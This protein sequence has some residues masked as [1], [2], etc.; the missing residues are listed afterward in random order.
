MLR[1]YPA[2]LRVV[3][4]G[5]RQYEVI[6]LIRSLSTSSPSIPSRDE[7]EEME[8]CRTWLDHF[9]PFAL[10]NQRSKYEFTTSRS[11]GPGGQNVNKIESKTTLHISLESLVSIGLPKLLIP[12]VESRCTQKNGQKK[13]SFTSDVYRR[14][15]DNK[16][17][18]F[19][20]LKTMIEESARDVIRGP[21][22]PD[23]VKRIQTR[24]KNAKIRKQISKEHLKAKKAGRRGSSGGDY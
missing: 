18:C 7:E 6:P 2:I 12:I 14:Q 22:D 1:S 16:R 17:E 19:A 13:L 3:Q 5:I 23:R 15:D 9:D 20:R 10:Q 11:S 4:G 21:T 24:E 8:R